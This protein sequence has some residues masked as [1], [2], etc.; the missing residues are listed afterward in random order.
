M[1]SHLTNN[2]GACSKG[3]I[4]MGC[5]EVAVKPAT[6]ATPPP[7][8]VK[9]GEDIIMADGTQEVESSI[10][11]S[12][13]L[14]STPSREL[15]FRCLT[16]KRLAH[17]SH[18]PIPTPLPKSTPLPQIAE[19]YQFNTVWLCMDCH[20][21][22][23]PLDKIIAWRP[24][25]PNALQPSRKDE[26]PN[27]K[28]HLPRE[29]LVKWQD[30]SYRRLNW[31]PHMWLVSTNV[32]KLKNFLSGGTK[33][34][35]LGEPVQDGIDNEEKEKDIEFEVG[36]GESADDGGV[37]QSKGPSVGLGMRDALPDAE[38]YIPP[39]WKTVDRV[40][41]VVIW[42]PKPKS[43]S[44][45]KHG[46]KRQIVTSDEEK[47]GEEKDGEEMNEFKKVVFEKGELNSLE[48]TMTAE[49]WEESNGETISMGLMERV[50]WAFIKW[51]DL[52]Y[53]EGMLSEPLTVIGL[54][55]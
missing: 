45:S 37:E 35:L 40:L 41:D 44:K 25:P 3:G 36:A 51:N 49:Q 28:E 39:A 1:F 16:C 12:V 32:G 54:H 47:D 17:Y 50:V 26:I 20:S 5:M 31:V 14:S 30:R 7:P 9:D 22:R 19:Y 38:R 42:A 4:C 55:T 10:Q 43:L 18:L 21:Y 8:P 13:D 33:I 52:G 48:N 24:Y 27:Y 23:F 11:N 2:I 15:L 29:Y 46:K 53:D 34:E 6:D